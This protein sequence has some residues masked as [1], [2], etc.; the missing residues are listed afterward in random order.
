MFGTWEPQG[1]KSTPRLECRIVSHQSFQDVAF[2]LL[3]LPKETL[4]NKIQYQSMTK[5]KTI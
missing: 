3:P 4:I 2:L 5:R 1:L